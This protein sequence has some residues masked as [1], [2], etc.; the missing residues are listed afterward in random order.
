MAVRS[1]RVI[2]PPAR[3]GILGG[4][5]LGRML[6]CAAKQM[7]F[8]VTVLDPTPCSPAGQVADRQIVAG[9]MDVKAIRELVSSSD[10]TTYEFEH[11]DTSVLL[12]LEAEGYRICPSASTLKKIQDKLTQKSMLKVHGI[13]VPDFVEIC[14]FKDL[15]DCANR[16]GYPFVIKTRRGGYD[17]KGYRLVRSIAELAGLSETVERN[18]L[19][20]ERYVDFD[21][22]L[23]V[24]AVRS[25]DGDTVLYPVGENMHE[26]GILRLTT[27]PAEIDPEVEALVRSTCVHV[28]DALDDAGVFCIE[29][30]LLS[31]GTVYV[32]EVAPRPHNSGHYTLEA[33]A[34]SQFEQLIRVM[35]GQPLG[36]P[37][38]RSSCAM[39]NILGVETAMGTYRIEGT[40]LALNQ[41]EVHVHIYGKQNT[42]LLKK[43]GHVTVL[44]ACAK[45]AA[46]LCLEAVQRLR[47]VSR[48]DMHTSSRMPRQGL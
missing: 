27:V 7:G 35:T 13:S 1:G 14:N 22:E 9:Y 34:T 24:M 2:Y 36:S 25:M 45:R 31:D 18:Q 38:L 41:E 10:V 43:I 17:G 11:L 3:I 46:T 21:Q 19:F 12:E 40:E 4:G 6:S 44:D 42:S 39:A 15:L 8:Y 16:F 28:L 20:A 5:Q 47:I 32:N 29:M 30:F 48:T 37:K 33:C 23:S 26:N